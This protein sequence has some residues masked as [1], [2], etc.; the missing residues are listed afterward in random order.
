VNKF[1]YG[2]KI[3]FTRLSFG[4][5]TQPKRGEVIVFIYPLE[6]EKDF[7]KRL[8]DNSPHITVSDEYRS[9]RAQPAALRWNEGA[10]SI[11]NVVTDRDARHPRLPQS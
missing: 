3:P 11:S 5:W 7:I 2:I 4:A 1:I 8:V 10:V 6:P 9:P